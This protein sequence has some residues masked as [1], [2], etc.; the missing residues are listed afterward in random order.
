M[1]EKTRLLKLAP[2]I[3]VGVKEIVAYLKQEGMKRVSA[4]SFVGAEVV[5]DIKDHFSGKKAQKAKAAAPEQPAPAETAE[6]PQ[7]ATEAPARTEEAPEPAAVE[8][9]PSDAPP[10]TAP[11]TVVEAKP[12]PAVPEIVPAAAPPATSPPVTDPPAVIVQPAAKLDPVS[13]KPAPAPGTVAPPRKPAGLERPSPTETIRQ[14]LS[15]SGQIRTR[16]FLSRSRQGAPA[17]PLSPPTGTR[18][19]SG[20]PPQRRPLTPFPGRPPGPGGPP[21]DHRRGRPGGR[22]H[23]GRHESRE[24]RFAARQAPSVARPEPFQPIPINRSV[25]LTEGVTIKELGERLEVKAKDLI[26]RLL[27][28][29]IFATMNQTLDETLAKDLSADFGA[30]AS[31]VSFEEDAEYEA[32]AEEK[33]E[34]IAPRPPVVTIMGHVD[35]GKTSLLDAIRETDVTS[36]EAG[37]ITQHIG[38]YQVEK[39]Q[40]MITFLDTPG[41]EAFT[42]M[43]AR[44]AKVTDIV[45]LVVAADDGVMPQTLEAI[46]HAR[47]AKVPIVVAINKIDRPNA[48]V[49]T[50]KKSLAANGLTPEDWGGDTVTVEVSAIEKT[51]LD[52]LLEMILLVADLQGLKANPQ[53]T[54]MGTIVEAK[55]DRGR[56]PVA[57][58]LVQNGT[59]TVGDSF[60]AGP[61]TGKVR[62]MLD[63]HGTPVQAAVPAMPVEVLGLESVPHAGDLFQVLSDAS[64]TRQIGNLRQSKLR[65]SQLAKTARLTP[66]HLHEQMSEGVV[67]ELPTIL[68]ADVQGSVEVVSE[69]LSKLSNDKVKVKIIDRGTGAIT[70]TNVL[71]ASASNAVIVGF[72][73]RPEKKAGELAS[74]EGVDIRLHTVIYKISEEIRN[75]MLGLLDHTFKEIWQGTAQV[76]MTFK[77]PKAGVVAGCYISDGKVSRNSKAR[78]LRDNVVIY[79]GKIASLRRFKDDA[80]EVRS[81]LEC[82]IGLERFS[83]IKNDDV[84]EAF[85]MEKVAPQ[86][87]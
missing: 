31:I 44:G 28:K 78:L 18:P 1:S 72:N 23:G 84:I 3:K 14:H 24:G 39:N 38:A 56:G 40:R 50:V 61:V 41:H 8:T 86:M 37:G 83:D 53:R 34:N 55:L 20:F 79:E 71:L 77:V 17:R 66:E 33:S 67:K 42:M 7:P 87:D 68:K 10:E 73:V 48:Q 4:S 36:Q 19:T 60:I 15:R 64:R 80:G 74:Q 76:R 6:K 29:G 54:A 65:E 75:A 70:E 35:H 63:F 26:K 49:D 57:T 52:L 32:I 45:V 30:E 16:P 51:N 25:T 13:A 12:G 85:T 59:L 47:A 27:D 58:V 81:G 11:T 46:N 21:R 43:R 69:T 82:G 2:E 9:A 5:Q 62:A 22:R